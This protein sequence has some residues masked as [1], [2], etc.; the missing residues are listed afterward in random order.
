MNAINMERKINISVADESFRSIYA[1]WEKGE[2]NVVVDQLQEM[3]LKYP[4]H[5]D[6]LNLL[7]V[8][9]GLLGDHEK[10]LLIFDQLLSSSVDKTKNARFFF[11]RGLAL[12]ELNRLEEALASYQ[13]AQRLDL[14]YVN[15]WNNAA[16][17]YQLLHQPEK[18][19]VCYLRMLEITPEDVETRLSFSIINLLL[20]NFEEGWRAHEWRWALSDYD[21]YRPSYKEPLW[22]GDSP[23]KGKTILLHVEQGLG[24]IIWL[25]RYAKVLANLGATVIFGPL[26]RPIF[27]VLR[28]VEGI[29]YLLPC[30]APIPTFDYYCPLFSLPLAF[31][32]KLHSI[33]CSDSYL[34]SDPEKVIFWKK[35]L[36][37]TKRIRIGIAWSGSELNKKDKERSL[38][39]AQFSEIFADQASYICLQH[40]IRESDQ[41]LLSDF[42]ALSTF[43]RDIQDLTD[44]AALIENVDLVITVDTAVAHLA[45]A[46]GKPVWVLLPWICDW[47]WMCDRTDSPWYSS[48]YLFRQRVKG[49]WAPVLKAVKQALI[50]LKFG[51]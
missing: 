13:E 46:M 18:A 15:A 42:P 4:T 31:R 51:S 50:E 5:F 36:P 2:Y 49:D 34:K 6:A 17:V 11:N 43:V 12:Q 14:C 1:V 45:G 32:T 3:L 26:S 35:R 9:K 10:A 8:S 23:I 40:E 33:P 22:L 48:M 30:D 47:R 38:S 7:G 39:L 29:H 41:T 44:V 16:M 24:D 27:S 21:L 28:G 20:G 37:P 25:S 19:L